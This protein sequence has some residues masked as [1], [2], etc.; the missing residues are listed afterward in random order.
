LPSVYIA[1]Y[2]PV[3]RLTSLNFEDN[4]TKAGYV[5]F[6]ALQ[7]ENNLNEDY[8]DRV[9]RESVEQKFKKKFNDGYKGVIYTLETDSPSKHIRN[10]I[11]SFLNNHCRIVTVDCSNSNQI[12]I[13]YDSCRVS[14]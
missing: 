13:V 1:N 6:D 9:G 4:T 7:M 2:A 5:S 14:N 8:W 11:L 3:G 12:F 10:D